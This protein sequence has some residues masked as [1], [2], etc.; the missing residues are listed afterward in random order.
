MLV[1]MYCMA[2][3]WMPI[4]IGKKLEYTC[5]FLFYVLICPRSLPDTTHVL[6]YF[7]IVRMLT[8]KCRNQEALIEELEL[9]EQDYQEIEG[10]VDLLR[11]QNESQR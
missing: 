11:K 10:E 5:I 3:C 6:F 4:W 2:E 1:N 9:R 7:Q 8:E